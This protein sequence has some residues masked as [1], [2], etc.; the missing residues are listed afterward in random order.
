MKRN[1]K[2]ETDTQRRTR[3]ESRNTVPVV[4]VVGGTWKPPYEKPLEVTLGVSLPC[5]PLE[6]SSASSRESN[7]PEPSTS[8]TPKPEMAS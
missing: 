3:G 1:A 7:P 6:S 4:V 2:H 5:P 8:P